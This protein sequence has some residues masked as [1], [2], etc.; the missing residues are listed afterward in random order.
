MTFLLVAFLVV[1][2]IF[3]P[4]LYDLISLRF[5]DDTEHS[6]KSFHNSLD[7]LRFRTATPLKQSPVENPASISWT[8]KKF[9]D[10]GKLT[11]VSSTQI[12]PQRLKH[13]QSSEELVQRR[14]LVFLVLITAVVLCLILG[15]LPGL[16]AMLVFSAIFGVLTITYLA[17]IAYITSIEK[18]KRAKLRYL[19][20]T[21]QVNKQSKSTGL[22]VLGKYQAN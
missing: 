18:E 8:G 5:F 9:A 7:K 12:R 14:R 13:Q 10:N 16:S 20:K 2:A 17:A 4:K 11:D 21:L 1:L 3:S 15:L 6:I 22:V 19:N